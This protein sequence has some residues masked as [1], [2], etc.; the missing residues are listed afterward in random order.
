V[1][2]LHVGT[3]QRPIAPSF[4][5]GMH[6]ALGL[7]LWRRAQGVP[8]AA[9]AATTPIDSDLTHGAPLYVQKAQPASLTPVARGF[10]RTFRSHRFSHP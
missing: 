3:A 7:G 1:D 10:K 6:R 2:P 8:R 5:A 4:H 9:P